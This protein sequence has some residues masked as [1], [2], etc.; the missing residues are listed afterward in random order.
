MS[1][2]SVHLHV[3]IPIVKPPLAEPNYIKLDVDGLE[4]KI[5][6]GTS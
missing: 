5:L 4:L 2:T 3:D 6:K 1:R